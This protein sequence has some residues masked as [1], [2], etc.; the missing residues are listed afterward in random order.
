[1]ANQG[2]SP[3]TCTGLPTDLNALGR[4]SGDTGVSMAAGASS[5]AAPMGCSVFPIAGMGPTSTGLTPVAFTSGRAWF[6]AFGVL[7][8]MQL[9][10]ALDRVC[11]HFIWVRP[12]GP[13][14]SF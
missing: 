8:V 2:N 13:A 4:V 10:C 11:N 7:S 1:M 9:L 3:V 6:L 14:S 12:S 5:A